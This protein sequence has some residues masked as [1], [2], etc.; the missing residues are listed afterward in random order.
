[1]A[2]S[3]A[4]IQV[5]YI[6]Q[7][8][9]QINISLQSEPQKFQG[10]N[11]KNLGFSR[12]QSRILS[13]S[14]LIVAQVLATNLSLP[15]SRIIF[16]ATEGVPM[17][18]APMGVEPLTCW[19]KVKEKLLLET[20]E[21]LG[22]EWTWMDKRYQKIWGQGWMKLEPGHQALFQTRNPDIEGTCLR[23]HGKSKCPFPENMVVILWYR[24]PKW[25]DPTLKTVRF[26]WGGISWFYN[27]N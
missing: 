18:R 22:M 26:R 13:N 27:K 2:I 1:M 3:L 9:Q 14:A 8:L 20:L 4:F 12:D 25:I 24:L 16:S 15:V 10:F 11:N 7:V 17:P 21:S 19:R 23:I 6:A 5:Q